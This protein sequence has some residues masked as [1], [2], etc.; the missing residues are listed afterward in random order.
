ML[1]SFLLVIGSVDCF[2]SMK[3]MDLKL[4]LRG[5][6]IQ[7]EK[8]SAQLKQ[9]LELLRKLYQKKCDS[10]SEESPKKARK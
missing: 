8:Q 2:S 3:E 7:R 9:D 5:V 10:P 6:R 4:F 1:I